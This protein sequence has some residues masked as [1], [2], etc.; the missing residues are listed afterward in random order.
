MKRGRRYDTSGIAEAEFE[1]GSGRRVLKNLLG[2]KRKREMDQV[3]A[4]ELLRAHEEIVTLYDRDH[5]F[6][7]RDISK[8]HQIW[9]GPIYP[10][11]GQ[12]RKVNLTRDNFTFAAANQITKLMNDFEKSHLA[13]CTPCTFESIDEIVTAI[14]TV[15]VELV[16][17]HPFREGNGRLARLVATL[18]ALQGGLPPLNFGGIRGKVRQEYFHSIRAGLDRN[19]ESMER[20]ISAVISRTRRR[21]S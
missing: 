6:S 2:I 13:S 21:S 10:W 12:Y 19:Y 18:M 3:E 14:S 5:Q 9:L 1:P 11:A 8:M 17:I 20:I 7:A 16:L 15:H 4:R